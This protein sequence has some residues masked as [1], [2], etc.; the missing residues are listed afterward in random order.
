MKICYFG[1]F[2]P[3]YSRNRILIKGLVKN[4]Q[5]LIQCNYQTPKIFENLPSFYKNVKAQVKLLSMHSKIS[6]DAIILGFQLTKSIWLAKLIKQKPLILD[7]F[8]SFYNS[9]VND[10]KTISEKSL[11]AKLIFFFENLIFSSGK[12]ILADT[13]THAK[14]FSKMFNIPI[15]KFRV[16]FVGAE[17]DIFFPRREIH[18]EDF[19]VGFNGTYIPLQG[20]KY[21]IEAAEI[22]NKH[23][24]HIKFELVGGTP[25]KNYFLEMYKKV[26]NKKLKNI[27]FIQQVPKIELPYYIQR[28][29]VQLGIFGDS[30][31]TKLVIPNKAYTAIAMRKPLITSETTSIKEIFKDKYNCLLCKVADPE[32]LA[33]KILRL[34]NDKDLRKKI[35]YNGYKTYLEYCTPEVLG[36][37]LI[38][39]I[40]TMQLS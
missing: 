18:K 33:N 10:W 30:L 40:N 7:P 4:H 36:N 1:E 29:D 27:K 24:P 11:T 17:D 3:D 5:E 28:S 38:N 34:Y 39:I 16:I 26:K 19:V 31:K 2:H 37:K 21:I 22:L 13:Y 12:L 6:Y 23:H 32:D 15:D 35:E 9:Y 20:I 14:Y 25:N 8:I